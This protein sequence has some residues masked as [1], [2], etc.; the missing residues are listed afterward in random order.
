MRT[1]CNGGNILWRDRKRK[2][3]ASWQGREMPR[4]KRKEKK[5]WWNWN[6]KSCCALKTH[7]VMCVLD[8][9]AFIYGFSHENHLDVMLNSKLQHKLCWLKN[10][11]WVSV[12]SALRK[13]KSSQG[14]KF[15][16]RYYNMHNAR[17][18]QL[19][20]SFF[21]Q[22]WIIHWRNIAASCKHVIL[23]QKFSGVR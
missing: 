6:N 11:N 7:H 18:M 15:T 4:K 2:F 22:R 21:L 9:F 20:Q 23:H 8:K 13:K 1:L 17:D 5:R 12:K 19:V 16:S 14:W 10:F 3:V